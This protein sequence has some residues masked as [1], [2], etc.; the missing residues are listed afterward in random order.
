MSAHRESAALALAAMMDLVSR[1]QAIQSAV[2]RN[3]SREEIE[4]MRAAAHDVFD[5][6]LD[7]TTDAATHVRQIV[8]P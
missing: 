6:Y 3:A 7:H 2:I 1:G 5:A 4:A 8:Q